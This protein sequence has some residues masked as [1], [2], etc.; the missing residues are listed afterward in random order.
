RPT[1]TS[2]AVT[3]TTLFRS[4]APRIPLVAPPSILIAPHH[5]AGSSALRQS[6]G[7]Q[8]LQ[9]GGHRIHFGGLARPQPAQR[10]HRC[11]VLRRRHL[12]RK[13]TRLHSSH[14]KISY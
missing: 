6:R 7:R 12:D 2:H 4:A 11:A 3:Y 14:V 9:Q 1:T 5:H 13:S 10:H 8:G